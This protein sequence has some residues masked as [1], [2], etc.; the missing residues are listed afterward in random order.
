MPQGS[1]AR[2]KWV[3]SPSRLVPTHAR[4]RSDSASGPG[5]RAA[6]PTGTRVRAWPGEHAPA[7]GRKKVRGGGKVRLTGRPHPTAQEEKSKR[8][9]GELGRGCGWAGRLV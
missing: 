9:P 2:G 1:T 8:A 5:G 7:A 3:K 4:T 6:V